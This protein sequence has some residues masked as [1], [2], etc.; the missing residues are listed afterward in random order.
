MC[1]CVCVYTYTYT[2][3]YILYIWSVPHTL[4][5]YK[6]NRERNVPFGRRKEHR[7]SA[8]YPPFSLFVLSSS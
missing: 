2:Y 8:L 4:T 5:P 3:I 1:V 6:L 7:L